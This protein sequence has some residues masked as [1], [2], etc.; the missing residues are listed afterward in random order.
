[1][2]KLSAHVNNVALH[3]TIFSLPFAYMSAYLAFKTHGMAVDLWIFVWITLAITGA[4]SAALA[5]DNLAD[6]KYDSQQERLSYRAMVKGEVTPREAK[7]SIVIFLAVFILAVLQL[8]RIC[9]YLLPA[10][11]LPFLIYPYT[12]RF[13]WLCHFVLGIAI[14]MAPA[15]AW[16]AV[17]EEVVAMPMLMLCFAVALW[18]AAFDAVYGSQ[19]ESFDISQGLHSMATRFGAHG[20]L[21]ICRW[22]HAISVICFLALGSML[23][24]NALYFVGVCVAAV[25]LFYQH[26]I[27]R[28]DDYSRVTQR[29]FM[30]NG[31]VSIAMLLFTVFS[32]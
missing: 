20:A 12:K 31:I 16:V 32:I 8:P 13:T 1:M 6:L 26:R 28:A 7:I 23:G 29:Y 10:A 25:T 22:L 3:H 27:V 24:L 14:A 17:T 11:A 9:L 4:R 21:I 19:D 30:R 18:I 2:A 5:L 15:G